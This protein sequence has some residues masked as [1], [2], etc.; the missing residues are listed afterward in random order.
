MPNRTLYP[1]TCNGFEN[2]PYCVFHY[3]KETRIRIS[4]VIQGLKD[5]YQFNHQEAYER[6]VELICNE[7]KQEEKE[8]KLLIERKY[9]NSLKV[10]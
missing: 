9:Y 8:R 10:A 3:S 7:L 4:P 1:C 6:G 2:N 5:Q